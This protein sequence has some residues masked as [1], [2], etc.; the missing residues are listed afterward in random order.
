MNPIP[1]PLLKKILNDPYYAICCHDG[2]GKQAELEHAIIVGGRQLN[3]YWAII[4]CCPDH[5]RGNKLNKEKNR[6]KE[7]YENRTS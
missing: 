7:E 1:K 4:P 5:N 2:C 6:L 3:E